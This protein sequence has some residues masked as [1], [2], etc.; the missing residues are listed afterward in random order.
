MARHPLADLVCWTGS[1]LVASALPLL[2]DPTAGAHGVLLGHLAR[3]ND[4]WR[5]LD[6][7]AEALA[8]FR[9]PDSYVSPSWYPSKADHGRA[10]PTWNYVSVQVH[11]RLAV[12]HD[13]GWTLDLVTRLTE[14]HE[15]GRPDPWSVDDAPADFV[16]AQLRAIVGIELHISRI[17]AK[18]KLSQNRSAAD[19]DGVVA[20]LGADDDRARATAHAVDAARRGAAS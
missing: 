11:G 8:L 19:I 3:A 2:F 7:S 18:W 9:G 4:H 15:A 12:H 20:G 13:P 17:D 1:G 14:R 6:T 5:R 10:V 16:S